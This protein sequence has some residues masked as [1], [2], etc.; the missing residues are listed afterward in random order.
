MQ[1]ISF[2]ASSDQ[3]HGVVEVVLLPGLQPCIFASRAGTPVFARRPQFKG[4]L[5]DLQLLVLKPRR[6][7]R[8]S[9]NKWKAQP[10]CK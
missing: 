1:G 6:L 10:H 7:V 9:S 2:E 5:V 8:L 3:G 4:L